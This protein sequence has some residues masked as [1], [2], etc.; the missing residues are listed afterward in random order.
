MASLKSLSMMYVCI[1][2]GLSS[3]CL[4]YYTYLSLFC[5]TVVDVVVLCDNLLLLLLLLLLSCYR[6]KPAYYNGHCLGRPPPITSHKQ[7][8]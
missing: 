8:L 3:L 4:P 5:V 6:M 7:V 1:M 2:S